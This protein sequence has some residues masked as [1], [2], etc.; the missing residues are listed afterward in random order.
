MKYIMINLIILL[1]CHSYKN[2]TNFD[3]YKLSTFEKEHI[4]SNLENIDSLLLNILDDLNNE[5]GLDTCKTKEIFMETSDFNLLSKNVQNVIMVHCNKKGILFS[6]IK[7]INGNDYFFNFCQKLLNFDI[8]KGL[9]PFEYTFEIQLIQDP[10][11]WYG[12]FCI[13]KEINGKYQITK[14]K[15]GIGG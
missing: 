2:H 10:L 7:D 1:S 14:I 11:A 13:V 12:Y 3:K 6:R 5:F 4:I 8:R 9:E 15:E